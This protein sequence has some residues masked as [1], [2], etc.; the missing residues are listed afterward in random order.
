M[1]G[2]CWSCQLGGRLADAALGLGL[3]GA[4]QEVES[5]SFV[6]VAAQDAVG[7]HSVGLEIED[8]RTLV[9]A[10]VVGVACTAGRVGRGLVMKLP[11]LES[12]IGAYDIQGFGRVVA[13]CGQLP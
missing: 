13:A 5:S 9:V 10:V 3:I 6:V 4:V 2:D 11:T 8:I 1:N 12:L 7:T